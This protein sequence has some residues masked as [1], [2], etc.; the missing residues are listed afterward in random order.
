MNNRKRKLHIINNSSAIF[1]IIMAITVFFFAVTPALAQYKTGSPAPDFALEALEGE[2]YQLNQFNNKYKHVLLCFV[3]SDDSSSISK[4]QDL[5]SFF[6]DY[7]PRES[8]Q[9]ITVV[10]L[11]QD[12]EE[13]KEKFLT[14]QKRTEVPLL[15]LLDK[16]GKTVKNYQIERYP[17]ILLLTSDL[18][19]RRVY[20]RFTT[21]EETNFYQYL[22]FLFTSQ[23]SNNK[24][25]CEEG[26]CPPPPGFE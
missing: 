9:I 24:S 5:L 12:K 14:L 18:N 16:E 4:L 7:Q 26:V 20:D 1:I 6:A 8:Y 17:T 15:I 2:V 3:K 25:S 11:S 13:V 19:V 23:K 22:K 10:E 21:R